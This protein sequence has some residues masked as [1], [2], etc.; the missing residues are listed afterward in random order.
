[1]GR[2][3]LDTNFVIALQAHEKSVIDQLEAAAEAFLPSPVVGEL[4]Y[5]ARKSGQVASNI[6]RLELYLARFRWL[7]VDTLTA[8][9]YAQIRN[10]HRLIG[11][12]IPENDIWIAAIAIQ[13]NLTL[14][15]RDQHFQHVAG[16][17]IEAW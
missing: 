3:G 15:T 8:H 16:L 9:Q 4:Y 14:V 1:N 2:Y 12:P 11:R 7:S 13:H 5:G 17:S 6:A 10:A